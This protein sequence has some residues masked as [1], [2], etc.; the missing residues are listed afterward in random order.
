MVV[1]AVSDAFY[2]I[3]SRH[4]EDG[5]AKPFFQRVPVTWTPCHLGGQRPW[6]LCEGVQRRGCGRRTAILYAGG[7]WFRMPALPSARLHKSAGD[8]AISEHEAGSKDQGA[9]RCQP[10]PGRCPSGKTERHAREHVPASPNRRQP[11]WP[12]AA[13]QQPRAHHRSPKRLPRLARSCVPRDHK[14]SLIRRTAVYG[15]VCTVVWE[16]E[17]ARPTPIPIFAGMESACPLHRDDIAQR[18]VVVWAC[19]D[20]LLT[21]L[22]SPASFRRRFF[23][24]LEDRDDFASLYP[25]TFLGHPRICA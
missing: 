20:A 17:A 22:T 7:G 1:R 5:K 6:F 21:Y 23:G 2:L 9:A 25:S 15:P 18:Y 16:G 4:S 10:E 14:G 19:W 12:L 13:Q 3:R 11:T 24:H 8:G